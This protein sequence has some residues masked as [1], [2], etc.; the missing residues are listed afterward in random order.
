MES[1]GDRGDLDPLFVTDIMFEQSL[2]KAFE[3]VNSSG[4]KIP[5]LGDTESFDDI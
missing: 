3:T 4:T 1:K 5:H 2:K